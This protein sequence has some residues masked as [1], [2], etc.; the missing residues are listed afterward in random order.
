MFEAQLKK[1]VKFK[2]KNGTGIPDNRMLQNICNR[3][4]H[5][6]MELQNLS[7]M[8]IAIRSISKP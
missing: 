2:C 1:R 7:S 8:M 5:R 3:N 6:L 4:L